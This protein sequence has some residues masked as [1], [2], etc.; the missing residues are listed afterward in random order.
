MRTGLVRGSR[1]WFHGSRRRGVA[2]VVA[3]SL[4]TALAGAA[5]VAAAPRAVGPHALPAYRDTVVPVHDVASRPAPRL[6]VDQ[7]ALRGTM[8]A[9]WPAAG[10]AEVAPVA[11]KRRAGAL[12]VWIGLPAKPAKATGAVRA[13]VLDRA[14]T[15]RAGVRGLLLRLT[16]STAGRVGLDI[17]Y[18]A[19]RNAYGADWS[20]R[21]AMWVLPTCALST[22]TKAECAG[23]YVPAGNNTR[24]GRLSADVDVPALGGLVAVNAITAGS[25]GDFTATTLSPSASWQVSTQSGD[26]S[27]SYP[28]RTPPAPGALAPE[29]G[30]SYSS[31][32]ADG[33]TA[34]TN[35]QPGWT[36]Q[37]FSLWP[38]YV[39]R[40][41]KSCALDGNTSSGDLCWG[42][43]NA[44]MM[45]GGRS[46]QL[47]RD[48]SWSATN[49][50]WRP[51]NDDGS[52]ILHKTGAVNGDDDGEYWAVTTP[53][54]T[55]YFFGRS[56]LD[57]WVTNDPVTN[58]TW[59]V[60]VFGDDANE[61][62]HAATFA[63]SHCV[64]AWRWNLDYIVD[65]HHNTVSY[66]YKSES[67]TYN[68]TGVT[69]ATSYVRGGTL[70]KIVY[71]TRSD[72]HDT[73]FLNAP[74]V[75]N[76]GVAD[77]CNAGT[78]TLAANQGANWPDTPVDQFCSTTCSNHPSPSFWTQKKLTSITTT[79]RTSS[80]TYTP[81]DTWDLHYTFPATQDVTSPSLWLHD[82]VHT[83]KANGGSIALPPV[84]FDGAAMNNRVDGTDTLPPLNKLRI[85]AIH[86]ET[87]GTIQVNY[88]PA[89]CVAGQPKPAQDANTG[90]CYPVYW[91]PKTA[92]PLTDWFHKYV[93]QSVLQLD[94]VGGNKTAQTDYNYVG[95]GAWHYPDND[96]LSDPVHRT[97]SQWRGYAQ[98]EVRSG[99][100]ADQNDNKQTYAVHRYYRGMDG[101]RTLSGGT[102]PATVT[103]SDG[104]V[105]TDTANLDGFELE[106]RTFNGPTGGEV[107]RTINTPARVE[108][109]SHSTDQTRTVNAAMVHTGSTVTR[110]AL[111]A[112]GFRTTRTDYTYDGFGNLLTADDQGDTSSPDDNRCTTKEY[113]ANTG[114]WL[115][116]YAK[117]VST[118]G[119]RCGFAVTY[120]DDAIS[121]VRT[122]FDGQAYGTAPT[123]GDA[124]KLEQAASY[125]GSTPAYI[126]LAD[127]T[128]DAYGRVTSVSDALNRVTGT[129]FTPVTGGPVT[130]TSSTS[131]APQ[132]FVTTTTLD[133]AWGLPLI[134]TD[135]NSDK[136]E[137]AYDALGRLVSVW[138]PTNP[139]PNHPDPNF[140]FAY[141]ISQ[142][143]A[144]SV[145]SRRL[146]SIAATVLAGVSMYDG[147]LRQRQTQVPSLSGQG[148]RVVSNTFYNSRGQVRQ[149][150]AGFVT[151]GDP[152]GTLV[153]AINDN[154]VPAQT[155]TDY[156]GANRVIASSFVSFA[157]DKWHT[158]TSYGGDRVNVTPP[159][160]GTVT[161]SI[162]DARG[163]VVELRQYHGAA[164]SGAYDATT[165]TYTKAGQLKKIT[166][167]AGNH[168]DYDYDVLGRKTSE[169]DPDKGNSTLSYD[170]ASQ[171]TSSTDS[172]GQTLA[173]GYDNLGRKTGE[174]VG[175]LTGTQL[176]GWTYDAGPHGKGRP[177]SAVRYLN[178]APYITTAI[179]SHDADGM[180]I[181]QKVVIPA[182][183]APLNG[184]YWT[185]FGYGKD[186]SVTSI[187]F[188][189]QPGLKDESMMYDYDAV[190]NQINMTGSATPPLSYVPEAR[191]TA[192]GNPAVL[193]LA[194]GGQPASVEWSYDEATQRLTGQTVKTGPATRAVTTYGYD[195]AGN[196][197]TTTDTADSGPADIQCF[198]Y[199]YLRRLTDAWTPNTNCTGGP[200]GA[201]LAGPAP[202]WNT[203]GYD[204]V[205]NRTSV[206]NHTAGTTASYAY[207][208]AGSPQ[209]H[210]LQSVTTGGTVTSSY[211]YNPLGATTSRAVTGH[212]TQTLSYDA[213]GHLATVGDTSYTYDADGNRILTKDSTGTTL[214]LPNGEVHA[215]PDGTTSSTRYYPF[216]GSTIAV[217]TAA[218]LTWLVPDPHGTDT[219]T[220]APT[221]SAVSVRRS[222]PFG[223][224]RGTQPTAWPGSHGFVGGV[225]D[226][227]GLT[228]LGAR[229]YD[230]T[231]GRFTS[232]DPLIDPNDPQQLNGYAYA[233]NNP[234]TNSDPTGLLP[235]LACPGDD[236]GSCSTQGAEIG[237]RH[238]GQGHSSSEGTTYNP[239]KYKNTAATGEQSGPAPDPAVLK[240]RLRAQLIADLNRG[241][242]KY[243]GAVVGVAVFVGCEAAF[244]I[245][246][247][248]A[249]TVGCAAAAGAV[250]G[251]ITSSGEGGNPFIGA[252]EGAALG[253]AA[254]PLA[255]AG[256]NL[257]GKAATAALGRG[258]AEAGPSLRLTYKPGWTAAQR[259]AADAKVAALNDAN[260]IVTPV[261]RATASAASRYRSAGGTVPPGSD[262]DHIIDL[263]LGGADAIFNMGPLDFSVNRSLG[264]QIANQIRDL[265]PGTRICSVSI[266]AR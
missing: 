101:D 178:G 140:T 65:P 193:N 108:T 124:T 58:S 183:E 82:I 79:V 87:G 151:T 136:T 266:C 138:L 212:A 163:Q 258:A 62:C 211:A 170:N 252:I 187:S 68:M 70:D 133:P 98:V 199:D 89:Q 150:D 119:V 248:G 118:V 81:V 88:Y 198:A 253:A 29:L 45:L 26:F 24:I 60:P 4:A 96:E 46:T 86:N 127:T 75:V 41:Y 52:R 69:A 162:S 196:L 102:Q 180:P 233:N 30:L 158:S 202:Y 37:G 176:A 167:P 173:L 209:P 141:T 227:T 197:T 221:D 230:P 6:R 195:D 67:N 156:D 148:G 128:Y 40:Q 182:A 107:S 256:S 94:G 188:P 1:L 206:T 123:A 15:E 77:R 61:P 11:G 57:G 95:G 63:A 135:P 93:V 213:E 114:S 154:Q 85:T 18:S 27:W 236:T 104:T 14:T 8:P 147:F 129:S 210:A 191:Y 238:P 59:T 125:S 72:S 32:S 168:W 217:R 9:T 257:L 223:N 181:S 215:N 241:D 99:N 203:Y 146:D 78:C 225:Q 2:T 184:T 100:P 255:A 153:T 5:P 113:A 159:A 28:L 263:Q 234:T 66:F 144:S 247:F 242:S 106:V 231:T 152:T 48:P 189:H 120:P 73:N 186:H 145:T 171:L 261:R 83:G 240:A 264:A 149:E 38:G 201:T 7:G 239:G 13:E 222:D 142:T 33:Q 224:P 235:A 259:A 91:V 64:Q 179:T 84:R 172:T 251:A 111:A 121:D 166:D 160:G 126:K 20:A 31:G 137:R 218:G 134:T 109:A 228:H 164:P 139:R 110:T 260:L 35:N 22:P 226:S 200:T 74:A 161:T 194:A 21:L 265:P 132:S 262:V 117:R 122:S 219:R 169:S 55:S 12:P 97:W 192:L 76:F 216:A 112:G 237:D 92:A 34:A 115:V 43:D 90:R 47:I 174:F 250:Q 39:E 103:D 244:G 204:L 71:G 243:I 246:T 245:E 19:F 254:A 51:V 157:N 44:T 54:G 10:G 3:A 49:Q 105:H 190:G 175:S 207:P 36:G 155:F 23:R 177:S 50:L 185:D 229:E 205:G 232:V 131:P 16:P 53:D 130:S 214:Y 143:G 116:S 17:D 208:S 165:Y 42:N 220:I 249:G 25:T 80:G 56:R